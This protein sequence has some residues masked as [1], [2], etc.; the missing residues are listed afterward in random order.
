MTPGDS[1]IPQEVR[2]SA[3]IQSERAEMSTVGTV[4][5][6]AAVVGTE[7]LVFSGGRRIQNS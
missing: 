1:V 2:L 3:R 7:L 6:V 5:V 4:V